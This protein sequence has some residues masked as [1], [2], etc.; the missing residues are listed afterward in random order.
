MK[1]YLRLIKYINPYKLRLFIAAICTMVAAGGTVYLPWIIKDVVD[2]VLS[3]KDSEKL[4]YIVLSI[5]VVFIIRGIFYY[6]QSYLMSY[7]GQH[8]VIDIRKAVFDKLQRLSMAFYD[9]NKTG[10]IMSY[11]TNDVNAL[12]AALV[13]NI[14][15]MIT[16]GFILIASI[17]AML[18][19]DWKLFLFT[20]CTFPVVL[21]FIDFFGKKIRKSGSRIQEA[22]ADITSVLQETVSS[23]RVIKSFVREDYEINR[24]DKENMN[25]FRANMKY[26]QLSATLTPTIEFVAAI[27]VALILW[28]GGNSVINGDI[29]AGAL[30]AFLSYAVNISN[31]IKR[32]SRVI[33]YIQKA[34]AAAQRVF[35]VLDLR[36]VI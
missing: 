36:E 8:V 1:L 29:T 9:K 3:E 28:Y 10:T 4:T 33:G 12:Q 16:E 34:M 15:E 11:V 21:A 19:L 35:D 14:V 22:T 13:D 24:F 23:A 31:P 18:Y 6:G 30:V 26:V 27:G 32:L 7:V 5:I 17:C 25:N 20:F 2:Q